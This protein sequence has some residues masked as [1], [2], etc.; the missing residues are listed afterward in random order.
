MTALVLYDDDAARRFAPFALTRPAGEL[1]AGALL[2]R[3]R[4]ARVTGMPATAF[5][6][7]PHLAGFAE[8]DAPPAATQTLAA[9][10]ILA[11]A[12]CAPSL[13][14]TPSG[15]VWRC[16]GRIA[17]VR[18]HEPLP[19][20]QLADGALDLSSLA[21]GAP[22]DIGGWWI[23]AVWDLVRHLGAMLSADIA[24]LGPGA[25][26]PP[27]EMTVLGAHEVFVERGAYIEPHVVADATEGPILIRAGAR[28]AA[29][30]R[31]AGPLYIGANVNVSGG[32]VS[33]CSIGDGCRAN[34]E[35]S[36]TIFIGH[37]NKGH[38]GFVGDSVIGRWANF[39]AGT[40]T[41]NL[42]NSYGEVALWTPDGMRGTGMQFLG[43]F[44]GDHAKLGI[45][46]R[47][48]T[49]CVVGAGANVFGARVTPKVVP[50]F[51]WGEDEPFGA[52]EVE[53]FLVV[54]ERV[55]ARRHV[56]LDE[57]MRALLR[58]AFARRGGTA[59]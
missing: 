53:K 43:A 22:C 19:L 23:D 44:V 3:E 12:R 15:D 5:V 7:A 42:K 11:S 31:L 16:D 59:P 9:G 57:P 45:G 1:R 2:V 18:L 41:S 39:G 33:A 8:F 6:G 26:A 28:I 56:A 50:P 58:V 46:T 34:G 13:D 55:M 30:T 36:R 38:D 24:V 4:W 21:H 48:T 52:W 37:A 27:A 35:L 17:A 51:A 25:G 49:G 47:L 40:I 20:D 29:F 32:R 54:A 14:A 10:T